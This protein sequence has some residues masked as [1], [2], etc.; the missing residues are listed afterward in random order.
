MCI[1]FKVNM[2]SNLGVIAIVS[3]IVLERILSSLVTFQL[4]RYLID[5]F[6]KRI[7]IKSNLKEI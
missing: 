1:L 4:E 7:E 2:S 5:K 6:Q 3:T